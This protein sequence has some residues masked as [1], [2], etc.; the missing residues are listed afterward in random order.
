M[1]ITYEWDIQSI[2]V[3][4]AY[5]EQEHVVSRVVWKVTATDSVSGATKDMTGVQDLNINN[6]DG[7]FVPYEDVTKEMLLD[8]IKIWLNVPVIER[9]LIPTTYTRSFQADPTP[10][11]EA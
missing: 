5:N 3:I 10:T 1:A 4:P 9:G 8:W 6:H 11:P 2:D 7:D